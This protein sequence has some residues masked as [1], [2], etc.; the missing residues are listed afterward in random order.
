MGDVRCEQLQLTPSPFANAFTATNFELGGN[1]QS[2]PAHAMPPPSETVQDEF[3]A[4]SNT[5][6][7]TFDLNDWTNFGSESQLLDRETQALLDN[8]LQPHLNIGFPAQDWSDGQYRP[9]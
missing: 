8:I 7:T 2:A 5:S 9:Y 1:L 3:G 4:W 6:A